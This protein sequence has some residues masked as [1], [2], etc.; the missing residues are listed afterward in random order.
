MTTALA[1]LATPPL[2]HARRVT[3]GLAADAAEA[4]MALQIFGLMPDQLAGESHDLVVTIPD[5][6]EA[7][8]LLEQRDQEEPEMAT[9]LDTAPELDMS[10]ATIRTWAKEQRL[11]VANLGMIPQ[12]ITNAYLAAHGIPLSEQAKIASP[13]SAA[14]PEPTE[15]AR[16][17]ST[18]DALDALPELTDD[19][20]DRAIADGIADAD[21]APAAGGVVEPVLVAEPDPVEMFVPLDVDHHALIRDHLAAGGT[22]VLPDPLPED[23]QDLVDAWHQLFD[24]ATTRGTRVAHTLAEVAMPALVNEATDQIHDLIRLLDGDTAP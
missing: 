7:I 1:D 17:A 16:V 3:A 13:T 2:W 12:A 22:L 8:A 9:A 18:S 15:P 19:V 23:I 24:Q 4:R 5:F 21:K 10:P 6:D 11:R 14:L 20:I